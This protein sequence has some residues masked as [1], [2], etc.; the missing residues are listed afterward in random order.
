MT[1]TAEKPV[2]KVV[3]KAAATVA[4]R[5]VFIRS[6]TTGIVPLERQLPDGS[7][8]VSSCDYSAQGK[9]VNKKPVRPLDFGVTGFQALDPSN[10]SD[11]LLIAEVRAAK[12]EGNAQCEKYGIEIQEGGSVEAPP[13]ALYEKFSPAKLIERLTEHADML[14]DDPESVRL[15]LEQC[16]RFEL[17]T[18]KPRQ[19]VLDAID[20][21]G[22]ASGIEYGTDEVEEL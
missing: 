7:L 20:E 3:A 1:Q 13:I 15:F 18:E 10:T 2:G 22:E 11:A 19:K 21:L 4:N 14:G 8:K 16:A 6:S 12:A 9:P 5:T 17:Q